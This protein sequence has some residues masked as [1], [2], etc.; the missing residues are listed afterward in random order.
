MNRSATVFFGLKLIT[1]GADRW[2][3]V[4]VEAIAVVFKDMRAKSGIEMKP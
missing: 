1:Q 2:P 3:K 4:S